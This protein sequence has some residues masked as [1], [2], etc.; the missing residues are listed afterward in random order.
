MFD[1]LLEHKKVTTL[2]LGWPTSLATCI[3]PLKGPEPVTCM[4]DL[5]TS[6]G[7]VAVEAIILDTALAVTSS[8]VFKSFLFLVRRA[9]CSNQLLQASYKG[10]WI[11]T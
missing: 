3:K 7:Y 6:C 1:A 9:R 8:S 10:N 5:N 4:C 2:M 11:A